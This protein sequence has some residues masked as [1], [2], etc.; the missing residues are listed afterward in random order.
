MKP[1][2]LT[3]LASLV[4]FLPATHTH[5]EG[6]AVNTLNYQVK[7]LKPISEPDLK[8]QEQLASVNT[9]PPPTYTAPIASGSHEDWMAAA[10]ISPSDYGYVDYIIS[11]E[12]GWDPTNWYGK[13]L[14]Y[15]YDPATSAAGLPQALPYSKTGCA[16]GD[17]V[18]Q[19]VWANGY[20][21]K[22][23]G[24]AGSYAHWVANGNW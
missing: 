9:A 2:I 21:A 19:L 17:A 20:A 14:G 5:T 10:G 3:L 15:A 22:Y 16:W 23:G 12:S 8:P 7:F 4:L 24:W 1:L 13:S 18:C 6:G 11:H